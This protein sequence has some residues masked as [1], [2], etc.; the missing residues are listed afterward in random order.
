MMCM[1]RTDL[2]RRQ[3]KVLIID[4]ECVVAEM[5]SM[6]LQYEG[7]FAM[8]A[9]DASAA[10]AVT[11]SFRPDLVILDTRLPEMDGMLLLERLLAY[12]P[13]ML[14]ILLGHERVGR[15]RH[16]A[17]AAGD[18]WLA[19]P[20][21]IEGALSRVRRVLRNNGI[22]HA[23]VRSTMA[24]G[25]LAVDDE[26]CSVSRGGE[27]IVLTPTEFQLLRFLVRNACRAVTPGEIL[28]RVWK[29][30]YLGQPAQVRLYVMYLRRRIEQGRDPMIHTVRR[31]G[32]VIRPPLPGS[33]ARRFSP[34]L[35]PPV[36]P[37]P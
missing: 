36:R 2:N 17:N 18:D 1:P 21:S 32:Y 12:R 28:G 33:R 20:F 35:Q 16:L 23:W 19:K 24:V 15:D 9:Y 26:N 6:A 27:D 22:D 29:Y 30:D 3:L 7:A 34:T 5:L 31:T 37:W 11:R 25:D 10:L 8:T 13:G 14:T 4:A